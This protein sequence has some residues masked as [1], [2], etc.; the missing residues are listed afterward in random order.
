MKSKK[1]K[2][3]LKQDKDTMKMTISTKTWVEYILNDDTVEYNEFLGTLLGYMCPGDNHEE[4]VTFVR[5]IL[6]PSEQYK[7]MFN[8]NKDINI[9]TYACETSRVKRLKPAIEGYNKG[10]DKFFRNLNLGRISVEY[11]KR[12]D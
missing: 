10:I 4:R 3:L 11:E 1:A 6:K 7:Q 8:Y 2:F 5:T 12:R 9:S